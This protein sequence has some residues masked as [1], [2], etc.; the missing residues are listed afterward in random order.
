MLITIVAVLACTFSVYIDFSFVLKGY[1][2]THHPPHWLVPF[3]LYIDYVF[4]FG[5]QA[6]FCNRG[7]IN[8]HY[9]NSDAV[10]RFRVWVQ[11][12]QYISHLYRLFTSENIIT[13][14]PVAQVCNSM[15]LDVKFHQWLV[16]LAELSD[17][18]FS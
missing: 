18:L 14:Q 2:L 6:K 7:W 13:P 3:G 11:I 8:G 4:V 1:K 9:K 15:R 16:P 12:V 10:G 17:S 5:V